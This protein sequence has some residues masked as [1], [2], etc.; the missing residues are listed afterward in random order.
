MQRF[1]FGR[2][3]ETKRV[4]VFVASGVSL[5]E[6]VH[7]RRRIGHGTENSARID[8]QTLRNTR[9]IYRGHVRS[10]HTG[11]CICNGKTVAI[12]SKGRG[13]FLNL[14]SDLGTLLG[15]VRKL[16]AN[17]HVADSQV[18]RNTP[19]C[20]YKRGGLVDSS[21]SIC[22]ILLGWSQSPTRKSLL[23]TYHRVKNETHQWSCCTPSRPRRRSRSPSGPW[24]PPRPGG[25]RASGW[26]TPRRSTPSC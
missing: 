3:R 12:P 25:T 19:C 9:N 14:T 16:N 11:I 5:H 7:P 1:Y 2:S 26:C 13:V 24:P 6:P 18:S 8:P 10:P 23:R 22:N 21:T 15:F 17:N 4:S 20:W